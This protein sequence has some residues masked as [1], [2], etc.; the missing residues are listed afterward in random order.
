MTITTVKMARFTI[1]GAMLTE[2]AREMMGDGDWKGALNYLVDSLEGMTFDQAISI[3]EGRT[4]LTGENDNIVMEAE[5]PLVMAQLQEQYTTE[6]C[7]GQFVRSGNMMYEPYRVIDNL[8]PEDSNCVFALPEFQA[9]NLTAFTRYPEWLSDMDT[10]HAKSCYQPILPSKALELRAMHYADQPKTDKALTLL[11]GANRKVVVLFRQVA[12]GVTPF[13]R[14]KDNYCFAKAYASASNYLPVSG[15]AQHY[16]FIHPDDVKRERTAQAPAPESFEA[17]RERGEKLAAAEKAAVEYAAS[18][19]AEATELRSRIVA[20]ANSDTEYGWLDY[21]WQDANDG[22]YLSLRAPKRALQCYALSQTSAHTLMPAYKAFSPESFKTG[23]DNPYHT[24]V[25]L[26]CGFALDDKTYRHD[27]REYR[28][29]LDLMFEVQRTLLDFQVQVLARG[30]ETSGK[31]VFHDSKVIDKSCILVVPHAGVEFEL[32]AM[33]A[34][35][36]VCEAGGRLAHLVTVCR[37]QAKPIMRMEG[38]CTT[39]RAGQQLTVHPDTGRITIW[40]TK[41]L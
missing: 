4:R 28:A 6:Y 16:G 22:T 3:L 24:D 38:A 41:N 20:F 8:G 30:P 7:Y 34:G 19:A 9:R 26:G 11:N 23:D 18:K 2:R 14:E 10:V 32:Q 17:I 35:A 1:Q 5:A 29:I 12:A 15:F 27:S 33:A 40:P 25:W 39:F 37:E 13:W 31:V 36:V 21:R